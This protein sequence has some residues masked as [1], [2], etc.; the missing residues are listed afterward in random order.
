[1]PGGSFERGT[2]GWG[3]TNGSAI[4]EGN[5][6]YFARAATDHRS[7]RFARESSVASPTICVALGEAWVRFFVQNPGVQGS[8]LH[9]EAFVQD[10]LTGLVLSW[11]FDVSGGAGATG[12]SPAPAML[13]PNLLG[14]VTGTE[15]LT[16]VF[17]ATGARAAWGVD[18]V[19][20]DPFKSR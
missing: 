3:L 11:G 6:T 18:D 12:W 2:R 7:V 13:V 19:F 8:F 9:I 10:R 5:E 20:V 16:L 17:T 4:V 15:N 14:G 1:M